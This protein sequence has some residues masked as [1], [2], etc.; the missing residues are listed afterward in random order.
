MI[1]ERKKCVTCGKTRSIIYFKYEPRAKD[2][3]KKEC[4]VCAGEIINGVNL[5]FTGKTHSEATKRKISK[6][7]KGRKPHNKGIRNKTKHSTV[8]KKKISNALKEAHKKRKQKMNNIKPLKVKII[9]SKKQ[10]N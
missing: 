5:G 10:E 8:T 1:P 9:K 7:L 4:L 2:K 3:H 6:T